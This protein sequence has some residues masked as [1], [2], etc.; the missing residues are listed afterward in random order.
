MILS[1]SNKGKCV[2]VAFAFS[3]ALVNAVDPLCCPPK[4]RL[5]KELLA[6]GTSNAGETSHPDP[7][8]SVQPQGQPVSAARTPTITDGRGTYTYDNGNM[9]SGE[10]RMWM[11]HGHGSMTFVHLPSSR[12]VD[13][14]SFTGMWQDGTRHGLGGFFV[15]DRRESTFIISNWVDGKPTN[16]QTKVWP[17]GSVYTGSSGK[18]RHGQG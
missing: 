11:P 18:L 3:A 12:S 7:S 1:F 15:G 5:R 2:A 16:P 8:Q 10:F 13:W 4:K 9:Y 14:A 17:D 6:S